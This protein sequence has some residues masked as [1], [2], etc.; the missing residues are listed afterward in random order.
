MDRPTTPVFDII[1]TMC[2][3]GPDRSALI[4]YSWIEPSV[5]AATL[6]STNLERP[7]AALGVLAS[8]AIR[9]AR[10]TAAS[11]P[12]VL[13]SNDSMSRMRSRFPPTGMA[14][15]CKARAVSERAA[16]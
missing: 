9:R 12:P 8:T 11:A 7:A 6:F 13:A 4:Q 3:L 16:I 10:E 1:L 14:Q 15:D 5:L 2:V